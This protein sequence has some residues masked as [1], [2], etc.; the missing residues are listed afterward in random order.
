MR[1]VGPPF[2]EPEWPR[3]D[4]DI[5]LRGLAICGPG[6]GVMGVLKSCPSGAAA[7][8][9]HYNAALLVTYRS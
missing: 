6:M 9:H 5:G 8:T 2:R 3:I 4:S 7:G 1:E